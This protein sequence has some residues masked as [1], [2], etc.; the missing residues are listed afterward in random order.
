MWQLRRA[1]REGEIPKGEDFTLPIIGFFVI[2][3]HNVG[4]WSDIRE[5]ELYFNQAPMGDLKAG[6]NKVKPGDLC[7]DIQEQG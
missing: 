5:R 3:V 6:L 2:K 4:K 7:R 1:G